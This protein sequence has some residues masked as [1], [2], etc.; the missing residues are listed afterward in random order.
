MKLWVAFAMGVVL[1]VN[2]TVSAAEAFSPAGI[3][4]LELWLDASDTNSV[5]VTNG[6]VSQWN[7]RSTNGFHAVQTVAESRPGYR[8]QLRGG[9]PM[10]QFYAL[11]VMLQTECIPARGD[12]PRTI[13]AA[14]ANVAEAPGT[15]NHVLHYG[16]P[17]IEQAYGITSR[18]SSKNVWGNAYWMGGFDTGIP[19]DAGG[20]TIVVASYGNGMDTFTINGG[21]TAT[22]AVSL[23]TAGGKYGTY[24]IVIGAR[25]DPYYGRPAEPGR[26]DCGEVLAFSTALSTED[27]QTVE[28]Y[29]AHKWGMTAALPAD[30]PY[31]TS[32]PAVAPGAG[33][34]SP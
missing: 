5:T 9:L 21:A 8:S 12:G 18:G 3:R 33:M 2:V 22:H 28:G 7:D 24:G 26:F 13:I 16:S 11:G 14:L 34:G 17:F 23:D 29:L 4:G 20:G 10:L 31:K 1:A 32:P 15:I 25:I 19:S 27:R 30:H 6:R